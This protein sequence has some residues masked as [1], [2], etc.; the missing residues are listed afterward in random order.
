MLESPNDGPGLPASPTYKGPEYDVNEE[1][2]QSYDM[3]SLGCIYLEFATWLLRG[4]PGVH[5]FSSLRLEEEK[6]LQN[7]KHK[8]NSSDYIIADDKFFIMQYD[9]RERRPEVK[10]SVNKVSSKLHNISARL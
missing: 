5:V 8:T 4:W 10:Q 3:W 9:G 7:L 6:A 2:S 1:I